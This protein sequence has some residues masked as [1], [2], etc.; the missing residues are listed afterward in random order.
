MFSEDPRQSTRS[1]NY[2]N[3][4]IYVPSIV[5]DWK[6]SPN[7]QLKLTTSGVYGA[8]NSVMFDAFANVPDTISRVTNA[9]RARQVDIDNF[10]SLTSELRITHQYD[11]AGFR[12]VVSGGVQYMHNKL[13]RRQLGK[14]TTG[15]DFDLSLTDPQF[16]RDMYLATDN[17]AIFVEN[18]I[19]I[20][21][22]LSLS[23]GLRVEKGGTD[24]TGKITYYDPQ[25]LPQHDQTQLPAL[26]HQL[27]IQAR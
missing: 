6:V 4:D 10:K 21:P 5:L 23:P 14:G 25:N 27:A 17:I 15:S 22:R 2:F 20:T 18:L 26:R 24:T 16:G 7:T 12:N 8:R 13:R 3:P 11:I 19:F 9:Y 1:R